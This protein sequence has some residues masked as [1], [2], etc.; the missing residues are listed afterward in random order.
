MPIKFD[1]S[2]QDQQHELFF[3][4]LSDSPNQ[5]FE[6]VEN[7]EVVMQILGKMAVQKKLKKENQTKIK[8]AIQLIQQHTY[9]RDNLSKIY[10]ALS[11]Q[12]KKHI[13]HIVNNN[14]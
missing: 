6:N 1:K 12:Q 14:E 5:F 3:K 4:I 8:H 13:N 2:E 7:Y 9:F 10:N 11:E